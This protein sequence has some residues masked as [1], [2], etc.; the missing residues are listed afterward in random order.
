MYHLR[1]L[2]FSVEPAFQVLLAYS[3]SNHATWHMEL[4]MNFRHFRRSWAQVLILFE[5]IFIPFIS[6]SA[7]CHQVSIGRPT[8]LFPS[9]AH[10][11]ALFWYIL[12]PQVH[13]VTNP[14]P[15]PNFDLFYDVFPPC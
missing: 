8:L 2:T 12:I 9:G 11:V 4:L 1:Y 5:V 3:L 13:H 14:S 15:L 10:H 7:V 6:F